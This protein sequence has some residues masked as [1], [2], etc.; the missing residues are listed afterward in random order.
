MNHEKSYVN[1]N[2]PLQNINK[3]KIVTCSYG[4]YVAT[5]A[6]CE[7]LTYIQDCIMSAYLLHRS[8]DANPPW[9][10]FLDYAVDYILLKVP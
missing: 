7:T 5:A 3:C 10:A 8:C 9:L 6:L 4:N 1:I 2:K